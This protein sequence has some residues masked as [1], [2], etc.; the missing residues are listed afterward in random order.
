MK[1]IVYTSNTGHTAEYAKILGNKTSLP[2]Y[3]LD[4]AIKTLGK[5]S[6]VIYLGWLFASSL[7]GYK[8]AKKHF[9]ILAVCGV[10]LCETGCLAAEVRRSIRLPDEIPLFTLQGGIDKPRLRGINKA[11]INGLIKMLSSKKEQTEDDRRMLELLHEDKNYVSEEN[12]SAF[13]EWF[14]K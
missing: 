10:G 6:E 4:T 7:K 5:G 14:A 8:K 1:A 12:L 9:K 2:V 11:M 3:D 13:M